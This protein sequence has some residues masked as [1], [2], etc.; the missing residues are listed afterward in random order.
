ME[1]K[2]NL[3]KHTLTE[4]KWSWNISQ[5][6]LVSRINEISTQ[7]HR[8]TTRGPANWVV[9]GSGMAEQFNEALHEYSNIEVGDFRVEGDTY[10][11]DITITPI[12]GVE[13]ITIDFNILPSGGQFYT[14]TTQEGN[15]PWTVL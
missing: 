12:R 5:E 14:G 9:M 7:I 6:E 11:Q 4:P 2:K 1:P 15:E 13:N 3:K 8:N 10:T